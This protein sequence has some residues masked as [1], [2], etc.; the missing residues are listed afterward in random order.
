MDADDNLIPHHGKHKKGPLA[1]RY[2]MP[3]ASRLFLRAVQ[4]ECLQR[5]SF[6]PNFALRI[7]AATQHHA[8]STDARGGTEL[9][10]AG[11]ADADD[12]GRVLRF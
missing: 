12:A 5:F 8:R 1:L 3:A 10:S 2:G 11:G 4:R 6:V 9:S 7:D